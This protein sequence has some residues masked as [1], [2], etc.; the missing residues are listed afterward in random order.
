[1]LGTTFSITVAISINDLS[2]FEGG[3]VTLGQVV[4]AACDVLAVGSIVYGT[5]VLL[6]WWNPVGWVD[7]LALIGSAACFIYA[8]TK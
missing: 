4:D 7:G 3:K 8:K 6:N 2:T 5:G 1:M